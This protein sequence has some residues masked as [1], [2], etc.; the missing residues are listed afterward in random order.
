MMSKKGIAGTVAAGVLALGVVIGGISI[1]ER[2]P[3]GKVAVVY[4]PSHGADRTLDAGW[5]LIKPF[6]KTQ[7]YPSRI[8]I[9]E[10]DISVTTSDGKK[11]T[12]PMRYEYKVDKEKVVDIFKELGSQNIESIQEGYLTQRLFKASRDTVSEYSVIDIYG[13][14]T[15][16]AS[17]KITEKM[18]DSSDD[19]G[20]M[21]NDVTIGT[22]KLDK[23]TQDAIDE[24]VKTAQELEKL[25]LE[26]QIAEKQAEKKSIE[27]KGNA[28]A[29]IERAKGQAE[30]IKL[31]NQSLTPEYIKLKE[32]E[33]RMKFGWLTVNGS[34]SV[35]V[36]AKEGK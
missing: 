4:T 18:R 14:K 24:R 8:T 33:A 19:L 26:K 36:D 27:A 1:T 28:E 9:V 32:A 31:V 35:I 6:E 29:E 5:H 30:A 7:E 10:Q 3:E 17:A 2:I 12:L 25:N 34:D 21:V 13:Q 15:S 23:V 16:E 22:P 20:F 11:V